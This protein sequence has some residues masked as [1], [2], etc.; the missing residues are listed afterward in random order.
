MFSICDNFCIKLW[1]NWITSERV[2]N[3]KPFRNKYNWRGLN[4]PAN[5]E[6]R[7]TFE[8]NNPRIALNVLYINEIETCPAYISKTN[9]E[10]CE[11]I[12]SINDS[13]WRKRRIVL[14]WGKKKVS[15]LLLEVTWKHHGEFSWLNLEF[16]QYMKSEK[17]LYI[18]YADIESLLKIDGCTNNP[19]KSSTTKIDERIPCAY[20][21]STVWEFDHTENKHTV[22]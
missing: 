5:I 12:N 2:S 19:K 4:Y 16:N 13:K 21:M 17:M 22:E 1:R 11:K 14:S 20:W 9:C 7:K 3:I 18:I 6:K 10:N 15:A 8:K